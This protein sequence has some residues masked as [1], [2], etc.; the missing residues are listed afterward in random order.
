MADFFDVAEEQKETLHG[1]QAEMPAWM[2]SCHLELVTEET[3]DAI[4]DIHIAAGRYALDLETTGLDSRVIKGATVDRIVGF[5]LSPDGIRG[6]YIPIRH[7]EGAQHNLR[8]TTVYAAIR[9]L[10]ASPSVAIFH[11]AKFDHAFLHH[12]GGEPMGVWD[13]PHSFECTL[14]LAYLENSKRPRIGLKYMAEK[15]LA[16]K[17]VELDELFDR[18][19][20]GPKDFS[21]LSPVGK[22][23]LWYT[24]G[25]ALCTYLLFDYLHPRVI[26]PEGGHGKG[27]GAV[28]GI[29]KMCVPANRWMERSRIKID[30]EKVEELIKLGQAEEWAAVLSVIE[31]AGEIL[32]R[33]VTPGWVQIL[34]GKLPPDKRS[35]LKAYDPNDLNVWFMD[36][37]QEARQEAD[38]LNL[39]P[40]ETG[41]N[42][43]ARLATVQKTVPKLVWV[44]G[45][46]RMEIVD[47]P[48]VYDPMKPA[49]LG[50]MFREMG[51][52]GL[53]ATEKSGQVKTAKDELDRVIEE[54]GEQFPFMGL[55]KRFRETHKALST[56]LIPMYEDRYKGKEGGDDTIR[57]NFNPTKVD[58]GRFSTPGQKA[59][60]DGGLHGGTRLNLHGLPA[61]Y[62]PNR[63][64]CMT[65]IRECVVSRTHEDGTKMILVAIDYSGQELRIATNL[66]R[67]PK[68]ITEFFRCSSCDHSFDRGDGKSM[69]KPPPPF[70]PR[71]GSD[72]IGDLHTLTAQSIFG[73][74]VMKG[75]DGKQ[76]RQ[77]S[78]GVNFAVVYGGGPQAVQAAC[79]VSKEEGARI[80]QKYDQTYKVLAGAQK[81]QVNFAKK[82][83]YAITAFGRRCPLPDLHLPRRDPETGRPNFMFISKAQRNAVNHPVQGSGGDIGKLAMAL[84]Y[85]TSKK[86]GWLQRGLIHMP[87]T[88][89]DELV[90]EI[91][92]SIIEEALPILV[93][94]MAWETVKMLPWVVPLTVDVEAGYNWTVPW[95]IT[96]ME[97]GKKPWA[98][99]LKGMFPKAVS[100]KAAEPTQF[101]E[102]GLPEDPGPESLERGARHELII[103][104]AKLKVRLAYELA[105]VISAC[106]GRGTHPLTV[107]TEDGVVLFGGNINVAPLEF[108]EAVAKL[109]LT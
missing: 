15:V 48:V 53:R 92:P 13:D 41:P 86:H 23:V 100:G 67:E 43:K 68:W 95:N 72:K 9:R 73:E 88:I 66:T 46:E 42:R 65:R 21:L 7:Q 56:Y 52:Q 74:D 11:N 99:E 33:D 17:M 84:V 90:F 59:L 51:V 70:C 78:K 87:I 27:Q 35:F 3:L 69:P 80:K 60:G 62:D 75:P 64:E 82:N 34:K 36:R 2:A 38:R 12:N 109:G 14:I 49:T 81:V 105:E 45:E 40:M 39:D 101:E 44:K 29:E 79:G 37:V 76:K 57:V 54:A 108:Q 104:S 50:L 71:C 89:H 83:G 103:P 28:Y 94:N 20:K 5:C 24:C 58:T 25:D 98:E 8:V 63:P 106:R 10:V 93:Q 61:T 1:P 16:R 26:T 4:I 85:K 55:V 19:Y 30:P 6:Y 97:H 107:K 96:E 32:G 102:M 47:F 18:E 22:G 91:H 77:Q 31:G